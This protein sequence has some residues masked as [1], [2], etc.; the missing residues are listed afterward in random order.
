M[1]EQLHIC[2]QIIRSPERITGATYSFSSDLWSFGLVLYE[3][4]TLAYPYNSKGDSL[5]LIESLTQSPEP[6][7]PCTE[8]TLLLHDFMA[9]MYVNQ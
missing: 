6:T 2:N 7:I 5:E 9:K 1:W 3:L 8:E 4:Y